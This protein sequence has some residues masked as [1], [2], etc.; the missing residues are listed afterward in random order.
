MALKQKVISG[1]RWS[2]AAKLLSQLVM[3]GITI[4]VIRL[5]TPKDYGLMSMSFIFLSYLSMINELG[6]GSALIQT[7]DLKRS[8]LQQIYGIL[9]IVNLFLFF[10]ALSIAPSVGIFFSE[11]QIVPI[12][13]VLSVQFVVMPFTVIP[14]S[15]LDREMRFKEKSV[16]D[17][18]SGIVGSLTTLIFALN[19]GGVYSLVWGYLSTLIVRTVGINIICPFPHFPLFSLKG[20]RKFM[21]FGGFLTLSR[22]LWSLYTRAD[23][24][25]I[26]KLLGKDSL[27]FYSVALTLA[28]LPMEKVSGSIN[29]VALPAFANIQTDTQQVASHFLKAVRTMSLIS[30][31]VL[32][33]LS[34]VSKEVTN[35]LL[36]TNWTLSIVPLQVLSLV[37]PIRMISSLVGPLL[38]GLGRADVQFAYVLLAAVT[39]P[40]GIL[41]GSFWGLFG[42]SAAW[43]LVFPIVF[44][45]TMSR[46]T[47]ILKVKLANVLLAMAKPIIAAFTMYI[48]VIAVRTIF[49]FNTG[50]VFELIVLII[51]GSIVYCAVVLTI[52]RQGF[53]GVF[54]L[55]RG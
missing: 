20:M 28:S 14:Q 37:I 46:V 55:L 49:S 25:I 39:V 44:V 3:W 26:G 33:G 8:S 47:S 31:P 42:V 21:S 38:Q 41:I 1:L 7:R 4:I 22:T 17:F 51:T 30:F 6:L 34:S 35:V 10:L 19:N 18:I 12:I 13:H 45:F 2:V 53:L 27:G 16:V 52:D 43:A 15:L 32:W 23:F 11:P 50:S 29:Q 36:G 54:E 24:L 5:L 40:I 48:A 9:I